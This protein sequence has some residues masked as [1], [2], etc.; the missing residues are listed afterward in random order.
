MINQISIKTAISDVAIS[1]S[2]KAA[3]Y[4]ILYAA[5]QT[6]SKS[7]SF[8]LVSD[9]PGEGNFTLEPCQQSS[10]R[11]SPPCSPIRSGLSQLCIR[12]QLTLHREE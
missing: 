3:M 12:P 8:L 7:M 10:E 5:S 4:K 11:S 1:K 6:Q 2:Q 9:G